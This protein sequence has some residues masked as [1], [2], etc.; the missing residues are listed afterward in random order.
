MSFDV[1]IPYLLVFAAACV[2]TMLSVPLARAIAVRCKAIDFPSARRINTVPIPRMGGIAMFIG[3][4]V[5]LVVMYVGTL[6]FDWPSAFIPHPSLNINYWG[7]AVGV[8]IIFL[9]GAVDDVHPLKPWQKMLGQVLAGIIAASSGLL[10]GQIVNPFGPGSLYLGFFAYPI[11]VIYLVSY[12]NIINLIDG[13]DGLAS[14]LS[15]IV[16]LSLFTITFAAGRVDAAALSIA[17]CGVCIGFLHFNSHPAG[18]FMGD[19]GSLMLGFLLGTASLLGVRRVAALTTLLVP[20][21][22]AGVPIIDTAAAI[23]RRKRGHVSIGTPDK[24]HIQHRLMLSGFSQRQA[25]V[26]I[27][28]WSAFLAIC[29]ILI[30]L[31]PPAWRLAVLLLLFVCSAYFIFRLKLFEPVLQHVGSTKTRQHFGFVSRLL[32]GKAFFHKAA[33][34]RRQ[35]R[36]AAKELGMDKDTRDRLPGD[37]TM[38]DLAAA[39]AAAVDS[40]AKTVPADALDTGHKQ[41]TGQ[42]QER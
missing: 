25:V 8:L 35:V 29:A 11:T 42:K 20:L 23:I 38:A 33:G 21:I 30:T 15:A 16:A 3:L 18:I 31:I 39:A 26:L 2:V 36:T 40:D 4:C 19:S 32:R 17:V 9:T 13:L 22:I 28:G 6:A 14:G 5:A 27:Y 37:T 41:D 24:G 1:I 10:I 12:A 34:Q 7:I